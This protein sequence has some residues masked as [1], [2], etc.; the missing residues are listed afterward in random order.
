MIHC[1]QQILHPNVFQLYYFPTILQKLENNTLIEL[2]IGDNFPQELSEKFCKVLE[3]NSNLQSITFRQDD[4]DKYVNIQ[5]I[6][7]NNLNLKYFHLDIQKNTWVFS[8]TVF[9]IN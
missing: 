9:Q 1:P 8:Q 7:E 2:D 6:L 3:T 4:Q 5:K